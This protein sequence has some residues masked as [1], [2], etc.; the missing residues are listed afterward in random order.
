ML[1]VASF[2]LYITQT[3]N[4]RISYY[5]IP[6]DQSRSVK[7]AGIRLYER[8]LLSLQDIPNCCGFSEST[9]YRV[10]TSV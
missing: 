1:T 5:G 8:D 3:G 10:L 7:R 9:W 6:Q 2:F 4:F